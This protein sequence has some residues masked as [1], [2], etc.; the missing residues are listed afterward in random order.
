[1]SLRNWTFIVEKITGEEKKEM[2]DINNVIL[3]RDYEKN[4]PVQPKAL[5]VYDDIL[6]QPDPSTILQEL[7]GFVLE[8]FCFLF[9]LVEDGLT[10]KGQGKRSSISPHDHLLFLLIHLKCNLSERTI[11]SLYKISKQSV[12]RALS[13]A[14]TVC[15]PIFEDRFIKFISM[16]DQISNNWISPEFPDCAG[17]VD[18]TF[19]RTTKPF[20]GNKDSKPMFSGK[21]WAY[22]F[23]TQVIH[24]MNGICVR[25]DTSYSGSRHDFD[26]F[27]S[28]IDKFAS[29]YK[30]PD[31]SYYKLIADK[32]YIGPS[33]ISNVGI[34]TPMRES[35]H[36]TVEDYARNRLIGSVRVICENYYGRLKQKFKIMRDVFTYKKDH[37]HLYVGLC[38]ALTNYHVTLYPLRDN[39]GDFYTRYLVKEIN[40]CF[41][42]EQKKKQ[43]NKRTSTNRFQ[44]YQFE[45]NGSI[46]NVISSQIDDEII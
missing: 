30:K 22:G 17:I 25:Y 12:E 40:E 23:K 10:P 39:E 16:E 46:N 32:G 26:I 18:A 33:T 3:D 11:G 9:S 15:Q 6:Q 36:L 27:K 14:I 37:Y 21:H 7:T 13:K 20:C 8:E 19:Q 34:I 41:D 38:I 24:S 4:F 44:P 2:E 43:K 28:T 45:K 5:S 29:L 31:G 1:M 35:D 42:K